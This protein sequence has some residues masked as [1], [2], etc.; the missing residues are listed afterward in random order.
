MRSIVRSI[1]RHE[2]LE[3]FIRRFIDPDLQLAE[4]L[5]HLPGKGVSSEPPPLTPPALLSKVAFPGAFG[6]PDLSQ[7]AR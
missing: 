6:R 7:T 3:Q 2:V 5:D 4:A 1:R